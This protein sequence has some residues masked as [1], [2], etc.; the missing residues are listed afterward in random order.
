MKPPLL[1]LHGALGSKKQFS[2]LKPLLEPYFRVYDLNFEGHGGRSSDRDFSMDTFTQNVMEFLEENTIEK[3]S[4][5]GYSMGG[6]VALNTAIK[7][8]EKIDQIIT[9]GTKF[10]W[11]ADGSSK[12]IKF[13]NPQKIE[14]KIPHFALMLKEEHHPEDWKMVMNKTVSMMT[15]LSRDKSLAHETLQKLPHRV[16]VGIGDKDDVV[17]LEESKTLA[18]LLPNGALHVLKEVPHPI[19]RITPQDIVQYLK[20]VFQF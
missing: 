7:H 18:Q 19:N 9:L 14:E 16:C 10:D 12:L 5:F 4:I 13:M 8:P 6:Y 1:L 3:T 15:G 2:G 17:G 11:S 20:D